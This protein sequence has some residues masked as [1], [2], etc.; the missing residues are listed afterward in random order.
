MK[1]NNIIFTLV[2]IIVICIV[3]FVVFNNKAAKIKTSLTEEE[4]LSNIKE[5]ENNFY[6]DISNA[7]RGKYKKYLYCDKTDCTKIDNFNIKSVKYIE[8]L[9]NGNTVYQVNYT[10]SCKDKKECLYNEQYIQNDVSPYY[11][12]N[13]NNEIISNLGNIFEQDFNIIKDNFKDAVSLI[14]EGEEVSY[15]PY[16]GIDTLTIKTIDYVKTLDNSNFVYKVSYDYTCNSESCPKSSYSYYEVSNTF[17][18][19]KDL[20]QEI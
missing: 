9:L 20:G 3:L 18:I 19:I 15:L 13:E 5:V 12:V 14:K 17:E 1:K 6:K 10:W 7:K 2:L 8:T 11:E 4:K 16:S